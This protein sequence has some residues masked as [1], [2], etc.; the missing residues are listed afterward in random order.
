MHSHR[1]AFQSFL[2]CLPIAGFEYRLSN[3]KEKKED[4]DIVAWDSKDKSRV[5]AFALK[6]TIVKKNKGRKRVW[7]WVELKDRNGNDGWLYKK[8]T[9]V[10]YERKND[11]VLVHKLDF[12]RWIDT[13]NIARW[14]LPFVKDSWSAGNRL[15]RREGTQ[16][17]IF[18]IK[19]SDIIKN[20]KHYIW[21]K[22][23]TNEGE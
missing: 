4:I 8:C 7:G 2:D 19:L 21:K 12:K 6:K 16:E 10:V 17:A 5:F 11:F 9:F 20:C 1:Q 3:Q 23:N 14:D 15:Y 18:H 22:P 13:E